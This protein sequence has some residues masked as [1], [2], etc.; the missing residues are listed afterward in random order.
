[1]EMFD[2]NNVDWEGAVGSGKGDIS[3][4]AEWSQGYEHKHRP[5]T[6]PP[7]TQHWVH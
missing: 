6:L 3:G 5:A 2:Q 4:R 1:M 7:C